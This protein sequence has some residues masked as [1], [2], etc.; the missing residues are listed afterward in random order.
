MKCFL[1]K[2]VVWSRGTVDI[3][4]YRKRTVSCSSLPPTKLFEKLAAEG[5]QNAYID[6]G[7]TVQ[8]FLEAGLVD[9]MCLTR[10]PV[11]LG[12]GIPLFGGEGRKMHLKHLSTTSYSNGMYVR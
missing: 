5:Y 3:P 8:K 7:F 2:V 11:L 9:E 10:A 1:L 12:E 4:D 6:G